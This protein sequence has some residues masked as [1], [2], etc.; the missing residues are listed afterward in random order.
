MIFKLAAVI[1]A[2]LL[3]ETGAAYCWLCFGSWPDGVPL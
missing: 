2:A 3:I 1:A